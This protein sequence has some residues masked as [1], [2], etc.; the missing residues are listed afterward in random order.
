MNS[1]KARPGTLSCHHAPTPAAVRQGHAGPAALP[2][3]E[4]VAT[5]DASAIS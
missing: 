5:R 1:I 2:H 3:K 4:T